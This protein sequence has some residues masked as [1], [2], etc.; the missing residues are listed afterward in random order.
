MGYGYRSMKPEWKKDY[1]MEIMFDDV[2]CKLTLW[3]ND[4]FHSHNYSLTFQQLSEWS[5]SKQCQDDL[6]WARSEFVRQVLEESDQALLM[7]CS[8]KR[9]WRNKFALHHYNTD[10]HNTLNHFG[11]IL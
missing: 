10:I 2:G 1:A 9:Y 3:S 8:G 4:M 5:E 11:E 6:A 7:P